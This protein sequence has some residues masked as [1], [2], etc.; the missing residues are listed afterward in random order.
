MDIA[1]QSYTQW[2]PSGIFKINV[3]TV[4]DRPTL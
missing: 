4:I 2:K 1:K 3:Q